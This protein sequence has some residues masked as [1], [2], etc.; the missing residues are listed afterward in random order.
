MYFKR[1]HGANPFL[2]SR[3]FFILLLSTNGKLSQSVAPIVRLTKNT[4]GKNR[5]QIFVKTFVSTGSWALYCPLKFYLKGKLVP[6]QCLRINGELCGP[7]AP[8]TICKD[9][10]MH[11][12][13]KANFRF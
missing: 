5:Q 10:E 2:K 4:T 7:K 3:A 1:S 11:R 13:G 9:T 6:E 12:E 8:R